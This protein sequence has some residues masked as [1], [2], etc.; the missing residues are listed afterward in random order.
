MF[1]FYFIKL[2]RKVTCFPNVHFPLPSG[3]NQKWVA[4]SQT[5]NRQLVIIWQHKN[6][7]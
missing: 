2:Y 7:V 1:I 6:F 5:V 3:N 4:I